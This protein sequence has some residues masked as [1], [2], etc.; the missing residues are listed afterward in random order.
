M[1][2]ASSAMVGSGAN[3]RRL[4]ELLTG[5]AFLDLCWV[6]LARCCAGWSLIYWGRPGR[7]GED[8]LVARG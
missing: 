8:R 3:C 7:L 5:G 1:N 6:P 4:I 2:T